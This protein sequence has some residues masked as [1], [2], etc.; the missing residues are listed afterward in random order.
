MRL[1]SQISQT[2]PLLASLLKYFILCL[3][4]FLVIASIAF[5]HLISTDINPFFYANF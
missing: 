2:R 5:Y 3:L 4:F 1:F